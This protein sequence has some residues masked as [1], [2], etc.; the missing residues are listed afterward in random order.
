MKRGK[1]MCIVQQID[2]V[3]ASAGNRQEGR[4]TSGVKNGTIKLFV[5]THQGLSL[6]YC[7]K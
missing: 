3:L 4:L 1:Q 7:M 5:K 2:C 6:K